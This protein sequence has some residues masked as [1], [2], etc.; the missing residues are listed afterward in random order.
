MQVS[1]PFYAEATFQLFLFNPNATNTCLPDQFEPNNIREQ[2]ASVPLPFSSQVRHYS[3]STLTHFSLQTAITTPI[4][5]RSACLSYRASRSLSPLGKLQM[6]MHTTLTFA[7]R[8]LTI[9]VQVR[10]HRCDHLHSPLLV[11]ILASCGAVRQL[12]PPGTYLLEINAAAPPSYLID[13]SAVPAVTS[14]QSNSSGAVLNPLG[15]FALLALLSGVIWIMM[16]F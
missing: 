11:P 10:R 2:A 4:G 13:L 3:L 16:M 15:P 12:L 6:M 9:T 14:K 8:C 1:S 5:S 7:S